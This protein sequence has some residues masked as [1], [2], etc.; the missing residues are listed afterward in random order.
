MGISWVLLKM[1]MAWTVEKGKIEAKCQ[2]HTGVGVNM[3][4]VLGMKKWDGIQS[5]RRGASCTQRR[6][7]SF[8]VVGKRKMRFLKR[9]KGECSFGGAKV[10]MLH[11]VVPTF[12]EKKDARSYVESKGLNRVRGW[13]R[14]D[15]KSKWGRFPP[16]TLK[17]VLPAL[18]SFKTTYHG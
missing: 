2:R 7:H 4:K 8:T 6:H 16:D 10:S 18:F 15:H 12:S 14:R 3:L 11:V 5:R 1:G 9:H 17:S 13:S